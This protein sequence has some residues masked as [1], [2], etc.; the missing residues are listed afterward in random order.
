MRQVT[1]PGG[2]GVNVDAP[3]R[4]IDAD[5]VKGLARHSIHNGNDVR[6]AVT[7]IVVL[8]DR[9]NAVAKGPAREAV[10]ISEPARIGAAGEA[11]RDQPEEIQLPCRLALDYE[12]LEA[13][14][15]AARAA[16]VATGDDVP[17]GDAIVPEDA[18]L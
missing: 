9:E 3:G 8:V 5:C 12:I 16:E 17:A 2:P 18:G 10:R 1:I 13:V 14:R 7:E 4:H 15:G 11:D 6:V